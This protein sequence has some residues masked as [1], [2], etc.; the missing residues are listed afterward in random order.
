MLL[1]RSRRRCDDNASNLKEVGVRMW[2]G[3]RWLWIETHG[4][5]LYDT[6]MNLKVP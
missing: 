3:F 5:L 1:G 2:T 4:E 6:V